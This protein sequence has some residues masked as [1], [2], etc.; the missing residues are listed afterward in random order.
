MSE[1]KAR[2]SPVSSSRATPN[3][4]SSASASTTTEVSAV[5]SAA[6]VSRIKSARSSIPSYSAKSTSVPVHPS[7]AWEKTAAKTATRTPVYCASSTTCQPVCTLALPQRVQG[8][9]ESSVKS[10]TFRDT[11]QHLVRI[12]VEVSGQ[13][14]QFHLIQPQVS[15]DRHVSCGEHLV[16]ILV[17]G[18]VDIQVFQ[19]IAGDLPVHRRGD[20]GEEDAD[21]VPSV[22][23]GEDEEVV[24]DRNQA[25]GSA[26]ARLLVEGVQQSFEVA[27]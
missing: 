1:R 17:V 26:D 11:G 20:I 27:G 5:D 7:A 10:E 13:C 14:T 9:L 25:D 18:D 16:Y 19:D 3:H 15:E 8:A 4:S 21:V 24:G 6:A 12:Q 2:G 23:A 22:D